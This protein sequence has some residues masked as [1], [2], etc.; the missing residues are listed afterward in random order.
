MLF[1]IK[2]ATVFV[3]ESCL[4]ILK[5]YASRMHIWCRPI[6]LDNFNVT[7]VR[8]LEPKDLKKPAY[9]VKHLDKYEDVSNIAELFH[10]HKNTTVSDFAKCIN[11]K[12]DTLTVIHGSK[13][14]ELSDTDCIFQAK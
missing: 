5:Y 3:Y 13:T 11:R 2:N 12:I 14:V 6:E 10:F 8:M 9:I 7:T 4:N 1:Y